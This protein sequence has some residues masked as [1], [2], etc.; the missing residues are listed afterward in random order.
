M[1]HCAYMYAILGAA[2]LDLLPSNVKIP[3]TAAL[4]SPLVGWS[5]FEKCMVAV[6][7]SQYIWIL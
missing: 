6:E 1:L 5:Q 3:D 2:S 4:D 7:N